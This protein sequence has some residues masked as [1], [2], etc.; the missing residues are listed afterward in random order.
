[1][2][3]LFLSELERALREAGC[4]LCRIVR[5]HEEAWLFHTLW[6]FTGD[7]RVRQRF[8]ESFGLCGPHARL[9]I[10]VVEVHHLGGSGVARIYETVVS[11]FREEL[12]ELLPARRGVRHWLKL[13]PAMPDPS[14]LEGLK[15]RSCPLCKAGARS[16]EGAV[17]FLLQALQ[18]LKEGAFWRRTFK[19][20]DGLCNPHLMLALRSE[21]VRADPELWRF[22]IE[23]QLRRLEELQRR[24]YELQRKQSYD[25]REPVTPDEAESWQEAIRRF[26]GVDHETLLWRIGPSPPL[27]ETPLPSEGPTADGEDGSDVP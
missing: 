26:T 24:L 22:L 16:A 14:S 21:R 9:L 13:S 25:V 7:P 2:M 11:R 17:F 12:L 15:G 10:R 18:D 23:D 4:P 1:M 19:E 27:A 3:A 6:E 20:S 8:D 5:R